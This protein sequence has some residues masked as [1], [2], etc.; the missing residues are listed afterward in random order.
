MRGVVDGE[1]EE[2]RLWSERARDWYCCSHSRGRGGSSPGRGWGRG[3]R[4]TPEEGFPAGADDGDGGGLE[5]P[6]RRSAGADETFVRLLIHLFAA[7]I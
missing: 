5:P 4:C 6:W 7:A 2:S 1:E 3:I